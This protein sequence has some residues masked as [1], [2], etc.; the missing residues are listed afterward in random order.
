MTTLAE[1]MIIAG[2]DNRPRMLEK[3]LYDSWKSRMEFYM[4]NME[5]GRRILDLVQNA[6]NIVLQGLPPDVYAII[7]HHKV[8]KEIWDRVKLLM[9]GTKLSLQEK[10]TED[11]DAYDS[12]CDDVSNAKSILMANL[13]NYGSNVILEEKAKEKNN[14]SLTSELERYKERVNTFEQR[15]NV[16]L[17][18]RE[19]M[20]D[21][22]IDDMIK[23]KL[24][25]KEQVDSLELNLSKQI[26]EKESLLKRFV[27][28]QELSTEQMFWFHMSNPSTASSDASPIKVEAPSELSKVS[29]VN[30]SLKNLKFHLAIYDYMVKIRTTLDALTK[31]VMLCVM[32]YTA[33]FDNVNVELQSSESCV[34]C[35]D[36]NVELLNKQNAYND[37]SESYPQLEKHFISLELTMQL[38]QEI[39]QKESFNNNQNALKIPEYFENNDLKAQLQAKDTTICK[40][41]EHIKSMRENDKEE[42]VKHE[43]DETETINIKLEHSVA[44]LLSEN[45]QYADSLITQLNFRSLENEDLKR[46]IQDKVFVITSLK[47]DL[48][49]LKGKEVENA[50]Q[51]AIATTVA[52]GM[53]KL[54]LDPLAPRITPI[55][56]V[57]PKETTSN[58]GETQKPKIKVYSRRLKQVKSIGS[59]KKAKIVESEIANNSE[60]T[61]LWGSNAIDVPSSS[62]LVNDRLSRLFSACA[63]GKSKK[64]SHRPKAK[65]TNQEKLY[66]LHMDLC[67]SMRVESIN[68]KKYILVIVDDYLRFTWVRFLRSKDEAPNAI[69]KCIKNIQVCLN[70]IVHNVQ[71]DN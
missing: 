51:I 8:S 37:L 48:H 34:K 19:K 29:L 69:I 65:D 40:L 10:S 2:A 16:D 41:K 63:L 7:N 25:L 20:I 26:K 27:P 28:Q 35:L 5:N 70:A 6:T 33:V 57:H 50:T 56:V 67:G 21:S 17:S 1:F 71:T 39:F 15:L 59:S 42:K 12:D 60:P 53:F 66:L 3:S 46:Q 62:S 11:L 68:E 61:Y 64:S 13:S 31:D 32:N 9:Q 55:K 30:E 52:P 45:E 14:E 58:S 44:K 24:A 38:N 54:D 43:M 4:K 23:E 36:L 47:N 49:K 18:S 22:Q